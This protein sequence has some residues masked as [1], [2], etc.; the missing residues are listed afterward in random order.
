LY[1]LNKIIK[2]VVKKLVKIIN[3][4]IKIN[5]KGSQAWGQIN[6]PEQIINDIILYPEEINKLKISPSNNEDVFGFL[7]SIIF[8]IS[9]KILVN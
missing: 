9:C 5:I 8:I 7:L 2:I 4:T 3:I 6:N 1:N